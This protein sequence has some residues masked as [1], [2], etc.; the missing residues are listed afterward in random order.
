MNTTQGNLGLNGHPSDH[1]NSGCTVIALLVVSA[2]LA[3]IAT[4]FIFEKFIDVICQESL[5]R[6]RSLYASDQSSA[7][8]ISITYGSDVHISLCGCCSI[9]SHMVLMTMKATQLHASSAGASDQS[10]AGAISITYGCG[11]P[12]LRPLESGSNRPRTSF[13]SLSKSRGLLRVGFHINIK[14]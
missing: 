13:R 14:T 3:G 5:E 2:C 6:I 4:S 9:T 11:Y 10:S 7:G 1:S 8:A 12:F